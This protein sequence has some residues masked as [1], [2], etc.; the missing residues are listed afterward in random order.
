MRNDTLALPDLQSV[1]ALSGV[2]GLLATSA[3]AVNDYDPRDFCADCGAPLPLSARFTG[4]C[5]DCTDE[6][7]LRRM[8]EED[9][10]ERRYE[11][12]PIE[13]REAELFG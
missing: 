2:R 10:D 13:E 3:Q 9:D 4:T 12:W 5:L 6:S 1:R 8:A 7:E 11:R